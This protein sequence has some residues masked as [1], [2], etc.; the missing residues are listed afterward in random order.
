MLWIGKCCCYCEVVQ[1]LIG[2]A[3][4][5]RWCNVFIDVDGAVY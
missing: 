4:A 1:G 2:V 5:V 3:V